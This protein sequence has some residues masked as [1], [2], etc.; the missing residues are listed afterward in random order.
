ME[1]MLQAKSVTS[2]GRSLASEREF[3]TLDSKALRSLF[4]TG[5]GSPGG[6]THSCRARVHET[7]NWTSS[8]VESCR[9]NFETQS[10]S[11]CRRRFGMGAAARRVPLGHR[12]P[13]AGA[14]VYRRQAEARARTEHGTQ[15]ACHTD[16][17]TLVPDQAEDRR[18]HGGRNLRQQP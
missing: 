12:E 5:A 6:L 15:R 7:E 9:A 13:P 10:T 3:S 18:V 14:G 17:I 11:S 1:S 2:I 8:L 16:P 4:R